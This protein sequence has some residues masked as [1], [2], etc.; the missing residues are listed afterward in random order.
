MMRYIFLII[1]FLGFLT[2]AAQHHTEKNTPKKFEEKLLL[3]QTFSDSSFAGK[4]VRIETLTIPPAS[5]DF[6]PHRHN[7]HLLGYILNGNI[8]TKMKDKEAL[9]LSQGQT[10]Y[11]YPNE[12]HEY[13]YNP[14]EKEK[15][16]ILLYYLYDKGASL[17]SKEKQTRENQ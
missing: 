15:A 12:L 2:C 6:A 10:F 1:C 14:N 5:K 16:V 3:K 4:E 9:H 7:C 8:V 11:E 17:Y 13:I